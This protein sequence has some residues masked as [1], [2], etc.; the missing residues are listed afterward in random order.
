M[1]QKYIS[2]EI[3]AITY[4]HLGIGRLCVLPNLTRGRLL[5]VTRY[6]QEC[7]DIKDWPGMR[8]Y[9]KNLYGYRLPAEEKEGAKF[10]CNIIF[11]QCSDFGR[12]ADKTIFCYP[13]SCVRIHD[14]LKVFRHQL[15]RDKIV[16]QFLADLRAKI[17]DVCGLPLRFPIDIPSSV[18]STQNLDTKVAKRP[19]NLISKSNL[20]EL[21]ER[22]E[23]V[24]KK[25]LKLPP[26]INCN[27]E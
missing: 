19:Y 25:R 27:E 1:F 9:W 8:R 15:D 18:E 16:D 2:G 12:P 11:D 5:S 23:A 21:E 17:P 7:S 13:E 20:T 4:H 26:L 24:E 10:Y 3:N 14:P 6:I 22:K